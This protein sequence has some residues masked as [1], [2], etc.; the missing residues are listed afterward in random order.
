MK[1]KI[2]IIDDERTV[3]QQVD[4]LLESFGYQSDFIPKADYMLKKL[5]NATFDLILM[6]I[7]MPGIDGLTALKN[8]KS[9]T[10]YHSIPVIMMT[11][12]T[13]EKTLESCFL[14][15]AADFI[16]KPIQEL[17]LKARV[18]SVI[19]KQQYT[20]EIEN[21][22]KKIMD[23]IFY[24]RTIQEA[25]LPSREIISNKFA[26]HF[27]MFKPRDI[28]SGDFYWFKQINNLIYVIA[29]D[30]T[31]HGVPGAFMSML[32]ISQLNE[33]INNT[34][35]KQPNEIL[36]ELRVRIKKLL[37][38]DQ[39]KRKKLD[40]MD[41]A[42]CV[43]DTATQTLNYSGAYSP[44]YLYRKNESNNTYELLETKADKMPIGVHPNEHKYFTNHE[45]SIQKSDT[46]YIFSDG[47]VSQFNN[48]SVNS[49]KFKTW[50]LKELLANI[51]EKNMNEQLNILE[52][53]FESWKGEQAQIDDLLI[54]GIR[55]NE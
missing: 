53:T 12:D 5:E 14:S 45:I 4:S 32:G 7:N 3:I 47:Y 54:I 52:Q 10:A 49:T 21:Q 22:Q 35:I 33:I 36:N 50:R 6:D 11:A 38:Q 25:M 24:A 46:I 44:L 20:Q 23:S 42:L 31:G 43:I 55:I 9:H 51:Q 34:E 40:G 39:Q 37:H 30:C 48:N 27:V 2:L 16:T 17:V 41:L 1:S 28:V 8:L 18:K 13:N 19:E 15:G 26:E 29:A